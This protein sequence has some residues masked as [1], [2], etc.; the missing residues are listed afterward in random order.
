ML[1]GDLPLS[2]TD[3]LV[4][5]RLERLGLDLRPALVATLATEPLDAYGLV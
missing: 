1:A 5:A 2:D 3:A 4:R